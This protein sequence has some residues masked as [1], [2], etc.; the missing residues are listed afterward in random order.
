MRYS[1]S[2]IAKQ[3][4]LLALYCCFFLPQGATQ[5]QIN[6]VSYPLFQTSSL[7]QD[8]KV[9]FTLKNDTNMGDLWKEQKQLKGGITGLI[10]K[11]LHYQPLQG[12][13][14]I[15]YEDDSTPYIFYE[16]PRKKTVAIHFPSQQH[17]EAFQMKFAFHRNG[18]YRV[19]LCF[20]EDCLKGLFSEKGR[21][22][23]FESALPESR[24]SSSKFDVTIQMLNI[25]LLNTNLWTFNSCPYKQIIEPVDGKSIWLTSQIG[26]LNN[27]DFDVHSMIQPAA[28]K[29]K[30]QGKKNGIKRPVNQ[31]DSWIVKTDNDKIDTIVFHHEYNPL[32]GKGLMKFNLSYP[33][34][35][36]GQNLSVSSK[37]ELNI[38]Y[39][40]YGLWFSIEEIE[41]RELDTR[42]F[43]QIEIQDY[44]DILHC[45]DFY[46][47]IPDNIEQSYEIGI[48]DETDF[49]TAS[50]EAFPIDDYAI[51][52]LRS[53]IMKVW[54]PEDLSTLIVYTFERY[55]DYLSR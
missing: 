48:V 8:Y 11:I 20:G 3:C 37:Y 45:N 44:R 13:E 54:R 43:V 51:D 21:I 35:L 28:E 50:T 34:L 18:L 4:L 27:I 38:Q 19:T 30:M 41:I 7:N 32:N 2:S 53:D 42:D 14:I 16:K 36:K 6:K 46:Y 26:I 24:W 17:L 9:L 52:I 47:M 22:F 31:Q 29:L 10:L 5:E 25:F 40:Y 55:K 12:N 33:R 1:L 39:H 23:L 49:S 15:F